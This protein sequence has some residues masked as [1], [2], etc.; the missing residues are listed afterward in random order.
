MFRV[1]LTALFVLILA[2]TAFAFDHNHARWDALLRAHVRW[3]AKGVASTVDYAAIQNQHAELQK[4]LDEISS[5]P[6][7]DYLGW[8][9]PQQLAFLINAYNAFTVELI[10]SK[11][12]NLESIKDLGSFFSSPLCGKGSG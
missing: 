12:P 7:K 10:L 2:Q 8:S 5:V 3:D 4:Y 6:L 9:R 1:S 11:Y